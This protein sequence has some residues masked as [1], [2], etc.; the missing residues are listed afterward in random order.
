MDFS[1]AGT[2][3]T[4]SNSQVSVRGGSTVFA[5]THGDLTLTKLSKRVLNNSDT[6]KLKRRKCDHTLFC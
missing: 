4:V 3:Q 2:K 5:L 1:L 6:K